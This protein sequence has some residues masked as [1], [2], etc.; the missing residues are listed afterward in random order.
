MLGFF[1]RITN[2]KIGLVITFGVLG[3]IALAF[4]AG[5]VTGLRS[6]PGGMTKTTVARIGNTS[7]GEAQLKQRVTDQL[8]EIRQQNPTVDMAALIANG[9]VENIL[10]QLISGIAL[11]NFGKNQGMAVSRALVGSELQS[12][13]ALMGP[14]GKF[15]QATYERI[16]Q[17]RR[18]TDTQVQGEI[19]QQTMAR[20]LVGPTVGATQLPESVALPYASLL[21]ERRV[22]EVAILPAAAMTGGPAPTDAEVQDFY[23]RN[24]ARYTVPERRVIRY[25]TVTSEMLKAQAQPSEAEIAQAFNADRAKYAAKERRTL[26]QVVVLDQKGA[27]ALAA[28]AKA[29]SIAD[30][31]RAAGL[32]PRT[33]NAVEKTAYA[34]QTSAAA[35]DAVFGAA[36][37]AVIG[38]I[39]GGI[40]FI[41]AK[42]D[43]IEQV[44]A[45]TLAQVH[46]EIAKALAAQKTVDAMSKIH[47]KL[48]DAI[49]DNANFS[50][51]ANDNK[52]TMQATPALTAAGINPDDAASKPDPALAEIVK[53]GFAAEEGD[54]PTMVQLA[55]DG[56]FALVSLDR[57]VHAAPRPLDKVRD[58]V[59]KD[60]AADRARK[61]ARQAASA[62]LAKVQKGTPL[63]QAVAQSG[64]KGASTQPIGAVRGQLNDP[65]GA[66][67]A[68]AL[69][70]SLPGGGARLLE[71]PNN[72]GWMVVKLDTIVAGDAAKTPQLVSSTRRE[73][74]SMVGRE[75]A[76][77]FTNAVKAE[78]KVSRNQ[79]EIGRVKADLSGK[80]ASNQ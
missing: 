29:G 53:A 19:A 41:V 8:N 22:G 20:F 17:Q 79:A 36:K 72:A 5:D 27:D 30:A 65:R 3:M 24:V 49:A 33:I 52:L 77:Q 46:D 61:A 59:A 50:E 78:L 9:G 67:P 34:G 39:K 16:L 54:S 70:F 37:G 66:N 7:I 56:S 21:L 31:A 26:T 58:A 76:E 44:P 11:E 25:A 73:L 6:G 68:L 42:V 2:S 40:G 45:K 47:D 18:L 71:A 43:A 48:D 35:A 51:L 75:Y 74:G 57:I 1:R 80:D 60:F 14:T 4:A 38:P 64:A 23:K 13:P 69:L 55:P 10:D 15:D 32:E 12:I 28:K 63:A 62:I